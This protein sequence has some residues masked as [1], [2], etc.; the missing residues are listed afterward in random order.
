MAHGHC[1]YRRASGIYAARIVV[2]RHLRARVGR[3]EIHFST[4][5]HARRLALACAFIARSQWVKLFSDLDN[6]DANSLLAVGP[7][8]VGDRLIG[9]KRAAELLDLPPLDLARQV[10]ARHEWFWC[11]A[12]GWPARLVS[13]MNNVDREDGC[14]TWQSVDALGQVVYL[15]GLARPRHQEEILAALERGDVAQPYQLDVAPVDH[16]PG[17][18]IF[19]EPG[20]VTLKLDDLVLKTSDVEWVRLDHLRAALVAERREKGAVAP[21]TDGG[22]MPALPTSAQPAAAQPSPQSTGAVAGR[23]PQSVKSSVAGIAVATGQRISE[24]ISRYIEAHSGAKLQG[25]KARWKADEVA[26]KRQKLRLIPELLGDF[27]VVDLDDLKADGL[28]NDLVELLSRMPTGAPL[29]T[30]R[31]ETGDGPGKELITWADAHGVPRMSP[32]TVKDYVEAL[33]G[34]LSWA[35]EKSYIKRNPAASILR[36]MVILN[37]ERRD[38]KRDPFTSGDLKLIFSQPWFQCGAARKTMGGRPNLHHRPFYYWIPLL[39]LYL[40]GRANELAQLYLTDI[41]YDFSGK[42]FIKFQVEHSDQLEV[43][44]GDAE[45]IGDRTQRQLVKPTKITDRSLK[46][47]NARREI[48]LHQ[49]LIDLGLLKYVEAL[50][51]SG[52]DR[53]FPELR[54]D[55]RKG[56]G[57]EARKWF[58][59]RL[60]GKS[61]GIPRNG[62]KVLHS[63]RH[64]FA[65]AISSDSALSRIKSQLLGHSRGDGQSEGRYTEDVP[66]ETLRQFVDQIDYKLP[67]IAPFDV[68]DGLRLVRYAKRL[69]KGYLQSRGNVPICDAPNGES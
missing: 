30:A 29:S 38:E 27:P 35:V 69:K 31:R 13:D 15:N 67:P 60:L 3:G 52:E 66:V 34:C 26:R 41:K 12:V 25:Y 42:P 57:L 33:A 56:Y 32:A 43:D 10:L 2:P 46:T 58:N 18:L 55:A 21:P 64:N 62:K 20:A 6:L 28:M 47:V 1:L 7:H 9:L 61:L 11:R 54:F 40:G 44:E 22:L 51:N 14:A 5:T 68:Q 23:V 16:H 45:S 59:E 39:S 19:V 24:L 49:H 36:S 8:L 17:D 53:L 48:P 4:G 37:T 65:S 50:R 63:M